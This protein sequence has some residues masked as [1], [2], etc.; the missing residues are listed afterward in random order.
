M[1][2]TKKRAKRSTPLVVSPTPSETAT[3]FKVLVNGASCHGGTMQWSLPRKDESGEWTPGE[4]HRVTGALAVC[5]NGLHLTHTPV[6]W[7]LSGAVVYEAEYALGEMDSDGDDKIAVRACRL[8]REV[9]WDD[10]QVWGEGEHEVRAGLARAYDSA[11]VRAYDSA[12]VEAS[13]S[14]TVRASGSATVRAYGSATVRAYG[15]AT[16][17]AYDSATVEAYDSAT[18]RA[19]G[20]ATVEASGSATVEAYDSANLIRSRWHSGGWIKLADAAAVIDRRVDG[21]VAFHAAPWS[22]AP[23]SEEV[24][25]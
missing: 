17:E 11:T 3:A 13:G 22:D 19:Y 4:W 18:V 20:S 21:T 12:T 10:H 15:S 8:M 1:T 24:K 7:W 6:N 5:S 25:P 16:V 2:A 9:S 23:A 14:A